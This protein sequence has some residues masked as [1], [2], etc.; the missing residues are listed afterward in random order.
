M[1]GISK[2]NIKL[3]DVAKLAD[4]SVGTVSR[5]INKHP[6]VSKKNA[7]KIQNAIEQLGYIP[8]LMAQNLAK[9]VSNNLLLYI[10]Q[11][12]PILESTWL[13]E[14][15]IIQSIYEYIRPTNYSLQLAMD[16][17]EDK[18]EIGRFINE[19]VN[20]KRV[21]GMII[22]STFE[23]DDATI[24]TLMK[25]EL[26]FILMGN[27][28]N[29]LAANQILFDNYHAINEVMD[30]LYQLG[31]RRIALIN[32]FAHQQHMIQRASAYFDSLKRLGLDTCDEWVKNANHTVDGGCKCMNEILDLKKQPT[33]VVCGNDD[34]AIG[35]MKAIKD[36]GFSI[37]GDYSITG[38]DDSIL[39]RIAEPDLTTV[40][41]PLEA[42]ANTAIEKLIE[43]MNHPDMTIP[44]KVLACTMVVRS[45]T[46]R[47]K[48]E[49]EL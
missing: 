2:Y 24:L 43:S 47:P 34:M 5:Y 8:N 10:L 35:A 28:T 36:R 1:I 30:Y 9:G 23:I 25:S 21:D 42:L 48:P 18:L 41:I 7:A 15:P 12:K 19:Y 31:H 3:R 20:S 29:I 22:L 44:K 45:S 26:P 32:G 39:S 14:L 49:Y 33:A 11:E 6:S 17:L 16:Y 13:Y 4:V 38:F 40:K 27:Q 46:G 37:P